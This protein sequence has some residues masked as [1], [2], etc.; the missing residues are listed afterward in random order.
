MRRFFAIAGAVVIATSAMATPA[1]AAGTATGACGPAAGAYNENSL[2]PGLFGDGSGNMVPGVFYQVRYS[3]VDAPTTIGVLVRYNDEL[4]S[5]VAV[6]SGQAAGSSGMLAGA[7]GSSWN[8]PEAQG[9]GV[10]TSRSGGSSN[11][12]KQFRFDGGG[13]STRRNVHDNHSAVRV[14]PAQSGYQ[15]GGGVLPG[16]YHFYI[17]TGQIRDEPA[18]VK[19]G[20]AGP[21]FFADENGLLGTFWCAV[22]D[23]L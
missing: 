5:Q 12:G 2:Y 7:L 15:G 18:T 8:N 11:R 17:Y 23:D 4:E 1:S 13:L 19:D 20:P 21:R 9:G 3:G 6:A 14:A 22:E 10:T 16:A